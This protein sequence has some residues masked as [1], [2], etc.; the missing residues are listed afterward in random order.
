MV[1]ARQKSEERAGA[2]GLRPGCSFD[3]MLSED[4]FLRTTGATLVQGN[5]LRVLRDGK[6]NYPAWAE[7]IQRAR[8]T[9]HLE[10]YI[11]HNDKT[12]RM[13]RDLLAEKAREGVRVRV[14]YD[15]FGS[16]YLL[17]SRMWKP[18][19]D[20]GGEV[21]TMN[22]PCLDSLLGWASRDHRKLLTVD[23]RQA[24]ISG[25]CIGQAWAGYPEKGVPPWR[26]T[27]VEIRGP[28]VADAEEAFAASWKL[29][30]GVI[31]APDLARREEI[32]AAG[33]V[34]RQ[35]ASTGWI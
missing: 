9:I 28:A 12:G 17:G 14:L 18:L 2:M 5:R 13:F 23:G 10:T 25:L 3:R 32:P 11:V 15:W 8:K 26:D 29:A 4:A 21:R 35:Q 7:A 19:R 27:G 22:P 24:F 20:A 16:L 1:T 33:P 34:R 31:P 30:G 6:E